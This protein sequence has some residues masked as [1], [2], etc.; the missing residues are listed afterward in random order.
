MIY[1]KERKIKIFLAANEIGLSWPSTR[2]DEILEDYLDYDLDG[3]YKIRGLGKNKI[4]TL[5]KII[6]SIYHNLEVEEIS[7]KSILNIK[8]FKLFDLDSYAFYKLEIKLNILKLNSIK[9]PLKTIK[10][11]NK[12][13]ILKNT[14]LFKILNIKINN[15][16]DCFENNND[17]SEFLS[18]ISLIFIKVLKREVKLKLETFT[19]EHIFSEDLIIK[20]EE[21][22]ITDFILEQTRNI[23]FKYNLKS[24]NDLKNLT[25]KAILNK[26]DFS[27]SCIKILQTLY[28]LKS[29]LNNI[30]N[31]SNNIKI[32]NKNN[33]SE[34]IRQ[35]LYKVTQSNIKSEYLIQRNIN[36]IFSRFNSNKIYT[37]E[38]LGIKYNLTRERI[39][40]IID[41]IITKLS[42]TISLN[43]LEPFW[44]ILNSCIAKHGIL[45]LS[46]LIN[47]IA[48]IFKINYDLTEE[49]LFNLI[50]LNKNFF[51]Y[52]TE[53]NKIKYLIS[54]NF[55]CSSCEKI[56]QYI[57]DVIIIIRKITIEDF[58]K[59]INNLC[60]KECSK[61]NNQINKDLILF[62]L[63]YYLDNNIKYK[64]IYYYY[65]NEWQIEFGNHRQAVIN[66]LKKVKHP[67]HYSVMHKKINKI[68]NDNINEKHVYDALGNNK[69]AI[70]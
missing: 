36:I 45:T 12:N 8:F 47:K 22:P 16:I 50:S 3:L 58:I 64:N 14:S 57:I 5:L 41:K 24:W 29:F 46:T 70:L 49:F 18:E 34:F 38:E 55:V 48:I 9:L 61:Y 62:N 52:I 1:R 35:W 54:K 25:E 65:I 23:L 39:R 51:K 7:N 11:F 2:K 69:N 13:K 42:S 40:Q 37:L 30:F 28:N 56:K 67:I 21:Y 66:Y 32:Q 31:N 17:F 4:N 60:L 43:L 19:D 20:L 15:L 68:R 10:L 63:E 44:F 27:F 6:H 53:K 59:K 33:F 26:Y